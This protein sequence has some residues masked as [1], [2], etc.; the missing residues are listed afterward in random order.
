MLKE[1]SLDFLYHSREVGIRA[2]H[3]THIGLHLAY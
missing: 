1:L 2:L 3:G